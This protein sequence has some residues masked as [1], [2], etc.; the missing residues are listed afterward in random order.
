MK[1]MWFPAYR[2]QFLYLTQ[3][4]ILKYLHYATNKCDNISYKTPI[5]I[6]GI[7]KKGSFR[8]VVI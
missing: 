8:I 3:T 6:V 5:K 7:M 4:Q 2:S 1:I